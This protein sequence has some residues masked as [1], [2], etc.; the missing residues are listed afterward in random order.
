MVPE[1]SRDDLRELAGDREEKR[2]GE[3]VAAKAADAIL[4]VAGALGATHLRDRYSSTDGVTLAK[5]LVH[6]AFEAASI[7]QVIENE[8]LRT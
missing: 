6:H 5:A 1:H 3:A 7:G 2:T 4:S 8:A